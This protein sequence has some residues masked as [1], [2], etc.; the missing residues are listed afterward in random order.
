MLNTLR[1]AASGAG[2]SSLW[3]NP[4]LKGVHGCAASAVSKLT[5]LR[6]WRLHG[7]A[8]SA[9]VERGP[10]LS[11][12]QGRTRRVGKESCYLRRWARLACRLTPR[13]SARVGDKVPSSYVGA[14]GAQLNR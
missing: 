5:A 1:T 14:R 7:R 11:K 8:E 4:I 3:V 12:M 6:S 9:Q 13:W 2:G 10:L